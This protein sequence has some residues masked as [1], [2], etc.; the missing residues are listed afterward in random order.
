[1]RI[2]FDRLLLTTGSEPRR[3]ALPGSELDGVHYL[4]SVRDSAA[5]AERLNAGGH[6]AVIGAGWIGAEVAASARQK[7]LDVTL[8]ERSSLPLEHIVGERLG[9]FWADVHLAHGVDFRPDSALEAFEGDGSV[10]RVHLAGGE[11]LECDFVVVG[12]G[13]APRTWLAE[14]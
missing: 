12:V 5:I 8:I 3:I 10:E 2:V 9:R 7:D 13:V 11:S 6:V 4:R 1:E 14:A